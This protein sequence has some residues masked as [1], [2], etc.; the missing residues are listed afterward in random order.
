LIGG[1]QGYFVAY[2]KIPAFIV[3]LAGMLIFRGLTL[4]VLSG[5][6]DRPLPKQN[7]R[8]SVPASSRTRL[9]Q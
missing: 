2:I 5:S 9:R 6:V 7:F 1:M 8:R 3:T 4:V